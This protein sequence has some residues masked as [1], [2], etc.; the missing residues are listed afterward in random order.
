MTRNSHA[1]SA[2][3]DSITEESAVDPAVDPAVDTTAWVRVEQKKECV[4]RTCADS[5][6]RHASYPRVTADSFTHRLITQVKNAPNSRL[7]RISLWSLVGFGAWKNFLHDA[8]TRSRYGGCL[9]IDP[10]V[11]VFSP[12]VYDLDLGSDSEAQ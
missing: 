1:L 2:F 4:R 5:S 9:R 10:S 8:S 7:V 12:H 6:R 11:N 3:V